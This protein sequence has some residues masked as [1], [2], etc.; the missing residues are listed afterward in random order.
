M[1]QYNYGVYEDEGKFYVKI[2]AVMKVKAAGKRGRLILEHRMVSENG[3]DLTKPKKYTIHAGDTVDIA[4]ILMEIS[5][6]TDIP[7]PKNILREMKKGIKKV[8]TKIK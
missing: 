1:K 4:G 5:V 8:V 2:N 6:T 7:D 3:T